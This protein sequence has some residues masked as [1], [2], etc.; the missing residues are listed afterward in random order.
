MD[1]VELL[2]TSHCVAI[3]LHLI[4]PFSKSAG[5]IICNSKIECSF[6]KERRTVFILSGCRP[7]LSQNGE[8]A[9]PCPSRE[10]KFKSHR[11][12][13]RAST[14]P[15]RAKHCITHVYWHASK[16]THA[17]GLIVNTIVP[18]RTQHENNDQYFL[19]NNLKESDMTGISTLCTCQRTTGVAGHA[20]R[21]SFERKREIG[22]RLQSGVLARWT[23][24][25]MTASRSNLQG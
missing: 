21:L 19:I 3:C 18:L 13:G 10:E 22:S 5:C 2:N 14:R 9:L 11:P 15:T 24:N 12:T 17:H 25:V 4:R 23:L 6:L 8:Y 7:T 20:Y 16:S 1:S